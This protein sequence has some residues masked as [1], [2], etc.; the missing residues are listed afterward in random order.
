[1]PSVPGPPR[2][3]GADNEEEVPQDGDHDG[4]HV[5]GDP[6]PLVLLVN[7]VYAGCGLAHGLAHC[8]AVQVG[9]WRTH[10]LTELLT[11]GP[12]DSVLEVGGGGGHGV[13]VE[14]VHL[15]FGLLLVT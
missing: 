12:Q 14:V 1:M 3:E 5:E 10:C 7:N 13:H 2:A 15:D 11:V 4:D 9:G 6:A 8:A